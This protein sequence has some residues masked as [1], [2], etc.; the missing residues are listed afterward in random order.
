MLA[1]EVWQQWL[2]WAWRLLEFSAPLLVLLL[3]VALLLV[4]L[5]VLWLRRRVPVWVGHVREGRGPFGWGQLP[6]VQAAVG[7]LP[8][9]WKSARL[10]WD[11]E[12]NKAVFCGV[13]VG[14]TYGPS[15][16]AE[17]VASHADR[18]VW[19]HR[20]PDLACTCGF[21][22][23]KECRRA[24]QLLTAPAQLDAVWPA[25]LCQVDLAGDV[26]EHSEGWRASHQRTMGVQVPAWCSM[27]AAK[28][29]T[30]R[31][32]AVAGR[33]H[34]AMLRLLDEEDSGET[35]GSV[36][37]LMAAMEASAL[38]RSMMLRRREQ[39]AGMV[40]LAP[41]CDG[42]LAQVT[43]AD[44]NPGGAVCLSV[45]ELRQALGTDVE[46][47]RDLFDPLELVRQWQRL[48]ATFGPTGPL[49]RPPT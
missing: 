31:A 24:L 29:Q 39:L 32:V 22:A 33:P 46:F 38:T 13:T 5:P 26:V 12:A 11:P 17:C 1:A 41:L 16:D 42:H 49:G 30:V 14:G 6:Q 45:G 43:E 15:A 36:Q 48:K 47:D 44:G 20:P 3:A 2:V 19:D 27:C 18:L 40:P 23:F 10:L 21:W 35:D 7:E 4:G 8:S 34:T 9:G 25:V 37:R 28:G